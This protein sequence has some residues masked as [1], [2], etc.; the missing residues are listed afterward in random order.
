MITIQAPR[1]LK[2]FFYLSGAEVASKIVTF[3]AI[4]YLARVAGPVGYGYVEF[5]GAVLLCAGLIVDQGFGPYGAREIAK[6]P[7]QTAEL[8]SEI[9]LVRFLLALIAY[10]V[11]ALFALLLDHPAVVTQLLLI[12][13]LSLLIT[14]LLL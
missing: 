9:V 5:A 13:G 7:Q 3:A 2:N 6:A 4:A 12:Y 14:P 11:V 10:A 8:V 1:L